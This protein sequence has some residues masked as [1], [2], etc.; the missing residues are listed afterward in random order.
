MSTRPNAFTADIDQP[1]EIGHLAHVGLDADRLV[2]ERHDLL[3]ELLGGV[4]VGD[5][6]DDDVGALLGEG[7]H[8]ALADAA[9]AAGDD[10]DLA[11]EVHD[12][13]LR[14]VSVLGR[15]VTGLGRA[16]T[17]FGAFEQMLADPDGVGHG[18]ESRVHCA[19]AREEAGVDDVEVVELVGLAVLVEHRR[20]RV[21]AEA[22][23]AAWWAT[24]AAGM[25]IWE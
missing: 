13:L 4:G 9:V 18:G 17:Y 5:V 11:G 16:P 19:D 8:D 23:R 7:E 3:L 6:V 15:M 21:V 10:C 24:P 12:L 2:A 14:S 1:L 20:S 22:A 25:F